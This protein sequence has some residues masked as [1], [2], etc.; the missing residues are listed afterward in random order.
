FLRESSSCV[1]HLCRECLIDIDAIDD[2]YDRSF[3]RHVLIAYRGSC[4][5]AESAHHHLTRSGA[6]SIGNYNDIACRL[7]IEIVR[8]NDQKPDALEIGRLLRGPNSAYYFR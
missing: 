3:D 4:R 1:A 5:L 8:M 6:E 7:F 2:A